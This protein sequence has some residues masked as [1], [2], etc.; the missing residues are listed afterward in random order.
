M[1]EE[2]IML[3]EISMLLPAELLNSVQGGGILRMRANTVT[4]EGLRYIWQLHH[5]VELD[6]SENPI[7]DKGVA[8]LHALA[9]LRL[10][11]LASTQITDAGL[12]YF[13]NFKQLD[14]LDLGQTKI[15]DAGLTHLIGLVNLTVISLAGTGVSKDAVRKLADELRFPYLGGLYLEKPAE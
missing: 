12:E 13:R 11:C 6:L 15:T 1:F 14:Y 10:L 4:D 5:L 2:T 7:T 3:P 9:N 8:H